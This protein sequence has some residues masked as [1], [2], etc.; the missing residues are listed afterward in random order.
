MHGNRRPCHRPTPPHFQILPC[1]QRSA[2]HVVEECRLHAFVVFL[3]TMIGKRCDVIKHKSVLLRIESRRIIRVPRA[4][5]RAISVDESAKRGIICRLLLRTGSHERQQSP[6]KRDRNIQQPAPSFATYGVC[7][8]CLQVH[9]RPPQDS[10]A[11]DLRKA[12]QSCAYPMG[13]RANLQEVSETHLHPGLAPVSTAASR[14]SPV[15]PASSPKNECMR[16]GHCVIS[17][18]GRQTAQSGGEHGDTTTCWIRTKGLSGKNINHSR[19]PSHAVRPR[20]SGAT[21]RTAG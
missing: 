13:N 8:F 20:L 6:R 10:S 15:N 21:P 7:I 1:T 12:T 3:P 19:L 17:S 9:L 11:L 18:Q 14:H 2:F 4:P 16:F 5:G